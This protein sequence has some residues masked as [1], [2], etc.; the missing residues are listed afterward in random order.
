MS[1]FLK[2]VAQGDVLVFDGAMG[3]LLHSRGL[4]AG[5][6]PESWCVSHPDVVKS[7]AEAYIASGSDVV[8]TNSFGSNS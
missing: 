1:A 4:Q 3:T 2:R 8:T 7:I 5:E 6:C